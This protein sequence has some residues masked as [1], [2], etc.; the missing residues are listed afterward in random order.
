MSY[1]ITVLTIC[2]LLTVIIIGI[3]ITILHSFEQLQTCAIAVICWWSG[4]ASLDLSAGSEAE[5]QPVP[6]TILGYFIR[7]FVRNCELTRVFLS[8]IHCILEAGWQGKE[9][10]KYKEI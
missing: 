3:F 6:R 7:N 8:V 2:P 4:V 10:R 9:N 5:P 1:E